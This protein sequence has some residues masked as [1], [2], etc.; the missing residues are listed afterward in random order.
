MIHYR[1]LTRLKSEFAK[2]R[3]LNLV[4]YYPWVY[5]MYK[6]A[7]EKDEPSNSKWAIGTLRKYLKGGGIVAIALPG[8]G[9]GLRVLAGPTGAQTRLASVLL[10]I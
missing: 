3:V 5:V 6:G 7:T 4:L 10:V 2:A 1:Y 8:A 9:G